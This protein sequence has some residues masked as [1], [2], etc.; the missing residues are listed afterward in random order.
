VGAVETIGLDASDIGAKAK[1][2]GLLQSYAGKPGWEAEARRRAQ[3]AATN[4]QNS[5]KKSP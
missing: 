3:E 1:A 2:M 5:L 4:V